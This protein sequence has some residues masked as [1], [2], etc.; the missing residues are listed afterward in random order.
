[1]QALHC[2][3]MKLQRWNTNRN[4]WVGYVGA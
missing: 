3:L 1:L 2:I 4:V